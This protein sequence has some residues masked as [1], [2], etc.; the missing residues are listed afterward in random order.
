M[1]ETVSTGS[2][3]LLTIRNTRPNF[4]YMLSE[5]LHQLRDYKTQTTETP[6]KKY[7]AVK[8]TANKSVNLKL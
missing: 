7:K 5:I 3:Y 8:K 4:N 2:W 6:K 1:N